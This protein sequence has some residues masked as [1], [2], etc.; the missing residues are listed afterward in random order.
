MPCSPS[1]LAKR[2]LVRQLIS[3]A[4]V[5]SVTLQLNRDFPDTDVLQAY[6]RLILKVHPD[7]GG[8]NVDFQCVQP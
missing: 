4:R 8:K 5:C 7:K 1:D 2:A 6:R 3:L